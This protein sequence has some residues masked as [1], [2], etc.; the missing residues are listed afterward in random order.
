MADHRRLLRLDV[1]GSGPGR[2]TVFDSQGLPLWSARTGD[3]HRDHGHWTPRPYDT[4]RRITTTGAV[5]ARLDF[6]AGPSTYVCG[7]RVSD[8]ALM[9]LQMRE[10]T[11]G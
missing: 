10:P 2:V 6:R 11:H 4:P 1:V 9:V 8:D 3:G 7:R 5:A